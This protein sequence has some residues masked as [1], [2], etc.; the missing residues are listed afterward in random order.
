M[1][2]REPACT[3]GKKIVSSIVLKSSPLHLK[4]SPISELD[5]GCA[6]LQFKV[7]TLPLMKET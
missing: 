1:G 7:A 6:H 2:R 5:R 4:Q 3:V